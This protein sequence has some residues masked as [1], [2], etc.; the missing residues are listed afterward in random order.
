MTRH[1]RQGMRALYVGNQVWWQDRHDAGMMGAGIIFGSIWDTDNNGTVIQFPQGKFYARFFMKDIE[2]VRA[3]NQEN[4]RFEIKD[5]KL[6]AMAD[7]FHPAQVKVGYN[8]WTLTQP[9]VFCTRNRKSVPIWTEYY[10]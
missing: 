5:A 10:I 9:R 7:D 6:L 8:C 1:E 2:L 4:K 3:W